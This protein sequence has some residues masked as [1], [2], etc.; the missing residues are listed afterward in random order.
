MNKSSQLSLIT[1]LQQQLTARVLTN[2]VLIAV[3]YLLFTLITSQMRVLVN[4]F[5]QPNSLLFKLQI[6]LTYLFSVFAIYKPTDLFVFLL[7][8]LL[9]G[10]NVMLVTRKL[11]LV[12]SQK[13]LRWTFGVGILSLSSAGCPACG[14]SLLSLTGFGASFLPLHTAQLSLLALGV[15]LLTTFYNLSSLRKVSCPIPSLATSGKQRR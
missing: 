3:V 4:I 2:S 6:S 14:F 10:L 1:V 12:N 11:R 5:S 15:L 7:I 8:S 9:I 13:N